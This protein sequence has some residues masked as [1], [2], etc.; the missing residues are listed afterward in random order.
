[1]KLITPP[2]SPVVSLADL[3]EYLRVDHAEQDALIASLEASAVSDLD[4]WNGIL[5]RCILAQTWAFYAQQGEVSSPMSDVIA[6]TQG[7]AAIAVA[8]DVMTVPADG[9]VQ[10]TCALPARYLPTV[11]MIVKLMVL[12]S[13]EGGATGPIPASADRKIASIRWGH[14]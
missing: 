4:G 12:H 5:G 13:Y 14:L 10:I 11:Q 2:A 6:A 8:D 3:K 7:G 9:E 1:M